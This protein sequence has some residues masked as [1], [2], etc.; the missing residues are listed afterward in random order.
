MSISRSCD[1]FLLFLQSPEVCHV[2]CVASFSLLVV[3]FPSRYLTAALEETF[4]RAEEK[5]SLISLSEQ[6]E[7][8]EELFNRD[9][10]LV[11]LHECEAVQHLSTDQEGEKNNILF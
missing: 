9:S 5:L 1:P 2:S 6:V 10:A 3:C 11:L 4:R 8:D 7:A